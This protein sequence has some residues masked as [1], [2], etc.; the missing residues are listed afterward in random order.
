MK[1]R[2]RG[3]DLFTVKTKARFLTH[4]MKTKATLYALLPLPARAGETLSLLTAAL[5]AAYG[6]E[7]VFEGWTLFGS[8]VRPPRAAAL[9]FLLA[10]MLFAL[11]YH[12]LHFTKTAAFYYRTDRNQPRPRCFISLRWGARALYC[13]ALIAARNVGWLLLLCLPGSA[14]AAAL[15]LMLLKGIPARLFYAGALLSAAQIFAGAA[16][17]FLLSRRYALTRYLMYLNPLLPVREAIRSSALLTRGR[18]TRAAL[19]ELSFLPW[20]ALCLFGPARPF[21]AAYAGLLSACLCEALYAEDKTR[22][23]TPAVVF[24]IGKKTKMRLAE[25]T[26]RLPA[27]PG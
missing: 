3:P 24:L 6:P 2:D 13:S 12:A 10:G 26:R 16:G 11:F 23:K 18:L 21:A 19:G 4:G 9:L 22:V 25:G 1:Y 15:G 27:S 14:T 5:C 8:P 20:R 17:A 7:K